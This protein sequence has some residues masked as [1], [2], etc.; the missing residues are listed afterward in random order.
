M[1]FLPSPIPYVP[2][3]DD[4]EIARGEEAMAVFWS[5]EK[6]CLRLVDTEAGFTVATFKKIRDRAHAEQITSE[7]LIV[8][9]GAGA[10]F[11]E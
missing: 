4:V 10:S 6:D 8:S 1:T 9:E 2:A 5:A 7:K 11:T 3:E